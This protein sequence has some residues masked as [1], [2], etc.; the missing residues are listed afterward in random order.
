MTTAD[1]NTNKQG[2]TQSRTAGR[3]RGAAA[4]ARTGAQQLAE[5]TQR[6]AEAVTALSRTDDGWQLEVE[7]LEIHRV[8]ET[9]DVM[10]VYQADLD[11]NGDL[12]SYRRLRRYTRAQLHEE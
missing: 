12:L 4:V 3:K 11:E 7:V 8:P 6:N 10:A 2:R 9:A 1:E 5:L